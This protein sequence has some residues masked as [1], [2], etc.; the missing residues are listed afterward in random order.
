VRISRESVDFSIRL[1]RPVYEN[2]HAALS[3]IAT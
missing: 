2:H 1:Y 3:R